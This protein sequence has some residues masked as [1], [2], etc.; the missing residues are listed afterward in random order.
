MDLLEFVR[1]G[2]VASVSDRC[3]R[4]SLP[5]E[6]DE[7]M[8][9]LV[10]AWWEEYSGDVVSSRQLHQLIADNKIPVNLSTGSKRSQKIR[11]SRLLSK[12]SGQQV[13]TYCIAEAGKRKNVR[14]WKLEKIGS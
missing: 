1:P 14:V 10:S 3:S 2:Y 7:D 13:G 12:I 9:S 11:L 8:I 4:T 6:E 5:A